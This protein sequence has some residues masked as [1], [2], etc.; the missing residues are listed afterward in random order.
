M[1]NK[2]SFSELI[3]MA[4][5]LVITK[6]FYPGARLIRRPFYIRGKKSLVYGKKFTTGYGCRFDLDGNKQTLFIGEDCRIGDYVHIVACEKVEIGSGCLLA[7]KIFISDTNHGTYDNSD[8][9]SKPEVPPNERKLVTNPVTIGNNV[10]I[11]DNVV[12][13]SG[14]QIGDG[15]II[16]ANSVVTHDIEKNSIVAG[17][18]A[19]CI[20]KWDTQ[21]QRW[22]KVENGTE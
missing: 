22:I 11:G 12:I 21:M 15:C 19:K 8:E 1:R 18:P 13:L 2:Y 16:G 6:I 4:Y 14:V 20:K 9:S 5:S 17:A 10:W 3:K 7:S